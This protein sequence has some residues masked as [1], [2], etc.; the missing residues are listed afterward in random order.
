MP[1][2]R[3]YGRAARA[4]RF[5]RGTYWVP[6]AQTRK[7]WVQSMLNEDTYIRTTS[8]TTS[9]GGAIPLLMNVPGGFTASDLD[10]VGV[11][12]ER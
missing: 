2:F 8:P 3:A 7:H 1:D 4:R 5:P 12:V 10:P 9:P 11:P 6:L